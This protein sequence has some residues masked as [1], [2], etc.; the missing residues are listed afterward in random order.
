METIVNV[1]IPVVV[2]IFFIVVIIIFRKKAPGT[3]TQYNPS[4]S[5]ASSAVD[6]QFPKLASML[7]LSYE[8][9]KVPN[10][11]NTL[12]NVGSR[13]KGTYRDV[14]IDI[15]MGGYARESDHTPLT[16][17]YSYEYKITKEFNFEVNNPSNKSFEIILKNKNIV[18]QPTGAVSFDSALMYIGDVKIPNEYLE[19]FGNMKW[20]NLKLKGNVLK[21]TDS[22]FEDIMETKGTM[23]AVGAVNPVWKSSSRNFNVDYDNVKNFIDKIIDLIEALDIKK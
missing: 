5:S 3:G 2:L 21:F 11:K 16:A 23:T 19:Y 17:A 14:Y 7:G 8:D 18:S 6:N 15:I 13:L 12:M 22:F 1:I 20:M 4:G 10:D 9:T